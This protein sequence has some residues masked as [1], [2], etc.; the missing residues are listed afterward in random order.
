MGLLTGAAGLAMQLVVQ[1]GQFACGHLVQGVEFG[2]DVSG[3][4]GSFQ[5]AFSQDAAV[6]RRA[7]EPH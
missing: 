3:H 6:N 4:V 2:F 7:A 1:V 5:A